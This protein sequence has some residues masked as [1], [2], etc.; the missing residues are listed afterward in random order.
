MG[1]CLMAVP[2]GKIELDW[3][4]GTHVFNVAPLGQILELQDKCDAGPAEIADRLRNGKWRANDVRETL[5]LGLIG[6]GMDPVNALTLV[7]RYVD[8]RPWKENV[9][10][11]LVVMLA[12]LVGVPGDEVGKKPADQ[13]ETETTMTGVL[14][15]P[16]LSEPVQQ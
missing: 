7:R 11:A 1:R 12:A 3:A 5:R 13:T 15:D 16:P 4:D 14:S 6:G 9:H 2:N 10:V 8:E